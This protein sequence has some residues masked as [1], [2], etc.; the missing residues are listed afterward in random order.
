MTCGPTACGGSGPMSERDDPYAD[1][2]GVAEIA[3]ALG[4]S[5]ARVKRWVERQMSTQCPEPVR[6][7]AC[8]HLYS[9]AE[10]RAWYALWRVTREAPFHPTTQERPGSGVARQ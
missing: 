7:L 4:V 2:A 9:L 1:L 8:G 10:W 6:V 3:A 5:R